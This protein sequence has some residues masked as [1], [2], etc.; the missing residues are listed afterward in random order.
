MRPLSPPAAESKEISAQAEADDLLDL[1]DVS[2]KR[3]ITTKLQ[4]TVT[5]REEYTA[6]ALEVMTRFA[7]DP[8]WLIY[9]PPTMSPPET[10]KEEGYLEHPR[11]ALAFYQ[12]EGVR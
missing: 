5:I 12:R 6:A 3:I 4:N 2:G 7:I 10:S 8:K 11:E 1:A 9:L